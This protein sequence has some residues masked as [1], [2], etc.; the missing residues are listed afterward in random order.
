MFSATGT[1][2]SALPQNPK[3]G[4]FAAA[5]EARLSTGLPLNARA[6][7]SPGKA[8]TPSNRS[9]SPLEPLPA[10]LPLAFFASE[11]ATEGVG[12]GVRVLVC[13]GLGVGEVVPSGDS[14]GVACGEDV[15]SAVAAAVRVSVAVTAGEVV[16][17]GDSETVAVSLAE[18]EGVSEWER[19]DVA[20]AVGSGVDDA[21]AVS[22]AVALAVRVG[23]CVRVCVRVW[24]RSAVSE[25]VR[26]C[27]RECVRCAE[28]EAA[29]VSEGVAVSVAEWL[30]EGVCVVEC[31]APVDHDAERDIPPC[32]QTSAARA[33]SRPRAG[34]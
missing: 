16:A 12:G 6:S 3:T 27:V 31:E 18:D 8:Y 1:T 2:S 15:R 17:S 9:Q 26:E 20:G 28:R 19:E 7:T 13:V 22:E 32:R 30:A 21:S 11:G 34:A 33:R 14:V 29:A 23:E 4:T 24:V 10:P 25:A 5:S